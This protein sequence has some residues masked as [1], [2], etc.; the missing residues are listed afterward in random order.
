[1]V[2]IGDSAGAHFSIPE[3]FFNA[4]MIQKGTYNDLLTRV[5]DE[6]DMPYESGYTGN[7]N[8]VGRHSVYK[9]LRN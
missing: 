2:V 3:K 8:A 4:S 9:Y 6:L 5:A 7:T 1:M